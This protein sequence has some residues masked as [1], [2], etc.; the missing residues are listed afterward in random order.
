MGSIFISYRR[1]DSEG[2]A[3]R[4]WDR[5]AARFGSKNVFMDVDSIDP[6]DRFPDILAQALDSSD[7]LVA[8]V[9]KN[10]VGITL[11]G[12]RRI[13]E[14]EDF[15]RQEV[16]GA[17]SRGIHVIPVLVGGA[18]LPP[19]KELPSDLATLSTFNAVEVRHTRFDDDVQRLLSGVD[20]ALQKAKTRPSRS[21]PETSVGRSRPETSVGPLLT[22][23]F[24]ITPGQTTRGDVAALLGEKQLQAFGRVKKQSKEQNAQGWAFECAQISVEHDGSEYSANPSDLVRAIEYWGDEQ[25][26]LGFTTSMELDAARQTAMKHFTWLGYQSFRGLV[27]SNRENGPILLEISSIGGRK[28]PL[29]YKVYGAI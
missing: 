22:P 1:S 12:K 7:V 2:Y 8:V 17:M 23:V 6:G 3:G 11:E 14:T 19:P 28:N 25:L 21:R 26:P 24:G 5:I 16:G 27:F 4:L 20:A 18:T 15:V 29:T 9:G 13:D 10:W